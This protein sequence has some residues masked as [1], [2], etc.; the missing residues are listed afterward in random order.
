MLANREWEKIFSDYG[1]GNH[2]FTESPFFITTHQIESSFQH[3]T[4]TSK[5]QWMS[6]SKQN[7]RESRPDVFIRNNLFLL[8]VKRGKRA[9]I[10]GEG[11]F[12]VPEINHSEDY[13]SGLDF[14]LDSVGFGSSQIQYLDFA[15]AS[16]LIGSFIEDDSLQLTLRGR[17]YMPSVEFDVAHQ[18]MKVENVQINVEAG[19]EGRDKLV[20]VKIKNSSAQNFPV[21]QLYYPFRYW[22]ARTNKEISLLLFEKDREDYVL[23]LYRFTD[24]SSY[25]SLDIVKSG[26]YKIINPASIKQ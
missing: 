22:A 7:R 6:L 16:S 13:S 21:R 4:S 18:K 3:L 14:Q 11:Y 12:D 15:Y 10:R 24:T 25:N 19:Y 26:K 9:I 1:I 23:W 20:L 17:Y 8:P 2:D 5:H